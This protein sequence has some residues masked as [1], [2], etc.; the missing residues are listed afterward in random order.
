MVASSAADP[1][2][3]S[4]PQCGRRGQYE[5]SLRRGWGRSTAVEKTAHWFGCER[6]ADALPGPGIGPFEVGAC[7]A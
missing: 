2:E 6:I 1:G 5:R 3:R 7:V 4:R